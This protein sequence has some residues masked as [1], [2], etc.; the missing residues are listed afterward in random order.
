MFL[1]K[2]FSPTKKHSKP[3][4]F[5]KSQIFN[6]KKKITFPPNC[7]ALIPIVHSLLVHIATVF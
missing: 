2:L 1:A 3:K 7:A 5:F 6:Q 4:A